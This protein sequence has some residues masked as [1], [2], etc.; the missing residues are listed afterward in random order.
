MEFERFQN[1]ETA[2]RAEYPW[3]ERF[4]MGLPLVPWQR[5]FVWTEEQSARFI[6]SAWTGVALGQY[7]VTDIDLVE[8]RCIQYTRLA[9]AVLDGQQ[10]LKALE[11]YLTDDL[12]VPDREGRPTLW[13]EL[14]RV[15]QR[16]FENRVFNRAT[17]NEFDEARLRATYDL[18]NFGGTPHA[19]HERALKAA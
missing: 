4:V 1:D 9:N 19:E 10:R 14:T 16:W 7:L 5:E 2:V 11:R 13:S 8:G 6:T 3:A 17:L 15:E 18:L 12:A